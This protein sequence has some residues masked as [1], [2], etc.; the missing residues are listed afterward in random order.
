MERI[1][2]SFRACLDDDI[3]LK[4]AKANGIYSEESDFFTGYSAGVF[5]MA[6]RLGLT[7]DKIKA[8]LT[9]DAEKEQNT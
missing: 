7:T 5:A 9:A 3:V 1:E 6:N 8:I 2:E 4:T